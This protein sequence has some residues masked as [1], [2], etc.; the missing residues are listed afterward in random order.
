MKHFELNLLALAHFVLQQSSFYP[1]SDK[2]LFNKDKVT[3]F[4]QHKGRIKIVLGEF[5]FSIC[6]KLMYK[7]LHARF[8]VL[9]EAEHDFL[10]ALSE[11]LLFYMMYGCCSAAFLP[12]PHTQLIALLCS[13]THFPQSCSKPLLISNLLA[14]RPKLIDLWGSIRG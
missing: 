2:Q 1:L 12:A 10:L 3:W 8:I 11:V 13:A 9:N 6:C 7:I 4:S 14:A 5:F